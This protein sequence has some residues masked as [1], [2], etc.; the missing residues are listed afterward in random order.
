MFI[1]VILFILLILLPSM[2][3]VIRE[4][5]RAVVFRLGRVIPVKGPGLIFLFPVLDNLYS[6]L[7]HLPYYLNIFS[8]GRQILRCY[9]VNTGVFKYTHFFFFNHHCSVPSLHTFSDN[10]VAK[11]FTEVPSPN[12]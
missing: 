2:F 11:A 9:A 3:R 7:Q 8:S 1:Y 12:W 6:G 10:I 4:Y 5:E